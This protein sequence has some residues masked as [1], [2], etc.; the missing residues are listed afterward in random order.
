MNS[1]TLALA[2]LLIYIMGRSGAGERGLP[3]DLVLGVGGVTIYLPLATCIVLSV[4]LSVLLTVGWYLSGT[5][6]R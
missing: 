3:G 2:G 1:G 6:R 5:L 4:L